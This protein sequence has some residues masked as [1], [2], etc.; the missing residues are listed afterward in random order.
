MFCSEIK[1]IVFRTLFVFLT[2]KSVLAAPVSYN[3]DKNF[4]SVSYSV[5]HLGL[6]YQFGNFSEIEGT[7]TFDEET[8]MANAEIKIKSDSIQNNLPG[9]EEIKGLDFLNTNSFPEITFR[10]NNVTMDAF[11]RINQVNG[12]LTF[13][14]VTKAVV[15][16]VNYFQLAKNPIN[17]LNS[18]GLNAS[19]II[20]RSDYG[21]TT[22]IKDGLI[23]DVVR[24]DISLEA[25]S[26]NKS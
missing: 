18:I 21:F 5:L 11:N 17:G 14:G 22:G 20:K 12:D 19:T 1:R 4:T 25:S 13:L 15:L 26:N 16:D 9:N 6:S 10:V 23:G 8:R 3:V 24:I 2:S 7:I